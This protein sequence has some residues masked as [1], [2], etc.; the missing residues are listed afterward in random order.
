MPTDGCQWAIFMFKISKK[1]FLRL[2][3]DPTVTILFSSFYQTDIRIA[4]QKHSPIHPL[5]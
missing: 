3:V 5:L 2:K 4:H 1:R